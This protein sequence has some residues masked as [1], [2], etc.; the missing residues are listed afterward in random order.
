[1]QTEMKQEL[2]NAISLI[3]TQRNQFIRRQNIRLADKVEELYGSV[4][5]NNELKCSMQVAVLNDKSEVSTA[6]SI[7]ICEILNF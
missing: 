5:L 1:M 3:I 7:L 6:C 4:K 2:K